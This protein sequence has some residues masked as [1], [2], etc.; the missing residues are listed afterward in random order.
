MSNWK[1]RDK[2]L[3]K[4]T[5]NKEFHKAFKQSTTQTDYTKRMRRQAVQDRIKEQDGGL[6]DSEMEA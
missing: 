3:E 1:Q 4:R 2:K 6:G 5:K